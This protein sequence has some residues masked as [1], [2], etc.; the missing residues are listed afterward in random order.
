MK[1]NPAAKEKMIGNTWTI[2]YLDILIKLSEQWNTS[3][4]NFTF[5]KQI[6]HK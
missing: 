1:T 6:K 3:K 4:N 2:N 5:K